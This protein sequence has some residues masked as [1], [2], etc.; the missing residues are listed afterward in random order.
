MVYNILELLCMREDCGNHYEANNRREH[1][2]LN[3]PYSG[4]LLRG[5]KI[6]KICELI[7]HSQSHTYTH[8]CVCVC[9]LCVYSMHFCVCPRTPMFVYV[10]SVL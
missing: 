9:I 6:C 4:L 10:V 8:S 1:T 2:D 7:N 5:P 3:L